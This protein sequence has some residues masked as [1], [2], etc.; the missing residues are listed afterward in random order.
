M[1]LTELYEKYK[2]AMM[3]GVAIGSAVIVIA[4]TSQRDLPAQSSNSDSARI[5]RNSARIDTL[6]HEVDDVQTEIS[7]FHDDVVDLKVI[8]CLQLT[9]ALR[10]VAKACQK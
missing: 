3:V 9:P 8:G 4:T 10:A 7:K 1:S 5:D 2:A 6:S